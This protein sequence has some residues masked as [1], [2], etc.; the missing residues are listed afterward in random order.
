MSEKEAD[1]AFQPY[2]ATV[3]YSGGHYGS[4]FFDPM[5]GSYIELAICDGCLEEVD[6]LGM[7]RYR[8]RPAGQKHPR[9]VLRDRIREKYG[10]PPKGLRRIE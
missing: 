4:T 6:K 3:F 7:I 8:P 9:E 2:A 5:D 10:D 1:D